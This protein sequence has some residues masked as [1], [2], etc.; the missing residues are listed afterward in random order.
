MLRGCIFY[1][2]ILFTKIPKDNFVLHPCR[3]LWASYSK[4]PLLGWTELV[5]DLFNLQPVAPDPLQQVAEAGDESVL[6][7]PRDADL[8]VAQLH[9][10]PAHLLHQHALR[11]HQNHKTPGEQVF[12]HPTPPHKHFKCQL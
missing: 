4:I 6:L 7:H 9:R 11:L 2:S 5:A 12:V 3:A 8:P 10:L 1:L